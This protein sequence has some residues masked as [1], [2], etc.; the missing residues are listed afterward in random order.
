MTYSYDR[1]ARQDTRLLGLI[2]DKVLAD[3]SP[4]A[5]IEAYNDEAEE[6]FIE[7]LP[8]EH[9]EPH[10]DRYYHD[11]GLLKERE[12]ERVARDMYVRVYKKHA[13]RTS[14]PM[15]VWEWPDH[16]PIWIHRK[17][18]EA[19]GMALGG[20]DAREAN[21]LREMAQRPR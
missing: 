2:I 5:L 11:I 18:A 16:M 9:A 13:P 3:R 14:D 4:K 6:D 21:T 19:I 8:N 7:S 20:R 17:V 12:A 1:R 15:E 10:S